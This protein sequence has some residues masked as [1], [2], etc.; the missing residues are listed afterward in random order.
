MATAAPGAVA[1]AEQAAQSGGF[2]LMDRTV[3]LQ[4]ALGTL[5]TRKRVRP[6][7]VRERGAPVEE[8][9][10]ETKAAAVE[11][12]ADKDFLH[13]SKDILK[14]PALDAVR[15]H[16]RAVRAFVKGN[17]VPS[18]FKGGMYLVRISSVAE[19]DEQLERMR[20]TREGLVAKFLEEYPGL[21]QTSQASLRGVYD[22]ADY[23]T[24]QAV[25]KAFTWE[26][27]FLTFNTPSSLK[28]ISAEI[29]RRETEKM[30]TRVQHATEEITQLL[31][32]EAND[33]LAHM[34]DRLTPGEDGKAKVFRNTMVTNVAEFLR[35]F[36][37]RN[38]V[39]DAELS[40][41]MG[42]VR[43]LMEGVDAELLR[44]QEGLRESI[45]TQ[46]GQ[47]KLQLDGMVVAK[48]KRNVL[49]DAD[50]VGA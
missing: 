39:D 21:V 38:V 1:Q 10:E 3:I 6:E 12:D 50:E 24:V 26:T 49:L 5:G 7:K 20:H 43:Q 13:V 48:P 4:L 8:Q 25:R 37:A 22:A 36:D 35:S 44:K 19:I 29:F 27:R 31:R 11:V 9:T 42:K 33:M 40:K 14:S 23:P 17:S 47:I 28:G 16:E 41:V 18:F 2:G 46:V 32:T 34:L 30:A 15:E 45:R